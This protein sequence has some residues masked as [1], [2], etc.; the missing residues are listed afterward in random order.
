MTNE[1][2]QENNPQ[3]QKNKPKADQRYATD[4]G[5]P[6]EGPTAGTQHEQ[7]KPQGDRAQQSGHQQGGQQQGGHVQGDA[8]RQQGNPQSD[9]PQQG[10]GQ[11]GVKSDD[12]NKTDQ[13]PGQR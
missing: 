10:G 8:Q 9:R 6:A 13:K 1:V 11:A 5:K 4:H 7:S 2:N 3:D 12:R